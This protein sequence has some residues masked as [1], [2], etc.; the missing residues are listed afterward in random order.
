MVSA[1]L[2]R[3]GSRS[4]LRIL[5]TNPRPRPVSESGRDPNT[6][7][8]PLAEPLALGAGEGESW[9][10]EARN[11]Q[12]RAPIFSGSSGV[13]R[14]EIFENCQSS[15]KSEPGSRTELVADFLHNYDSRAQVGQTCAGREAGRLA[16]RVDRDVGFGQ[17][18]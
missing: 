3:S 5:A 1:T 15:G 9:R 10:V 6:L 16:P 18:D 17:N 14:G 8:D 7:S 11:R 2:M 4:S 12:R 13:N